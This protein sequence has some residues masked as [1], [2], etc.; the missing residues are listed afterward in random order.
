MNK[1]TF[2]SIPHGHMF[3]FGWWPVAPAPVAPVA[4]VTPVTPVTQEAGEENQSSDVNALRVMEVGGP[5]F[6]EKNLVFHQKLGD[7]NGTMASDF[8]ELSGS[9]NP[10]VNYGNEIAIVIEKVGQKKQEPHST[11]NLPDDVYP[12]E[13]QRNSPTLS[14]AKQGETKKTRP[15]NHRRRNDDVVVIGP[16]RCVSLGAASCGFQDTGQIRGFP[17][18]I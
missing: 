6:A 11:K 10:M 13:K 3:F 17:A 18:G 9:K 5:R 7:F 2:Q 16:N 12:H 15:K 1:F 14:L 4:P 8:W